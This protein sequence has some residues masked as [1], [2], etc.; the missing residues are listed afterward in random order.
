MFRSNSNVSQN[1]DMANVNL[2]RAFSMVLNRKELASTVGGANT[3]ATTFTAPQ[4]TVNGMNFNK[5]FA[6]QN[7]TSKYTEFNKKQVKLYLTKP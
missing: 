4:E 7:A 2:R 1:K 5:Y 3:V 6:E